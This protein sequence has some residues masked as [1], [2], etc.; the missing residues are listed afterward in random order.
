MYIATFDIQTVTVK[1]PATVGG[2]LAASFD[3]GNSNNE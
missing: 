3:D 1:E 2:G